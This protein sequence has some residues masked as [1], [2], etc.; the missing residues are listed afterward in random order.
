MQKHRIPQTLAHATTRT[1]AAGKWCSMNSKDS[2][3]GAQKHKCGKVASVVSFPFAPDWQHEV[4]AH[5]QPEFDGCW[6]V[7]STV[8]S[9]GCHT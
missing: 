7:Q 6:Q 1:E 4:A 3:D 2:T 9:L 5:R 8:H